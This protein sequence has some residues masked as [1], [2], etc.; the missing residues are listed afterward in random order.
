MSNEPKTSFTLYYSKLSR[1]VSASLR[2]HLRWSLCK[3]VTFINNT[4]NSIH[5]IRSSSISIR[6]NSSS[7]RR[8]IRNSGLSWRLPTKDDLLI[9]TIVVRREETAGIGI[10]IGIEKGTHTDITTITAITLVT[11]TIMAIQGGEGEE[12][13]E[14][15]TEREKEKERIV[16]RGTDIGT[17]TEVEGRG[18]VVVL[19]VIIIIIPGGGVL[20][21]LGL[22]IILTT[23]N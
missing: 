8:S 20:P 10:A 12:E 7:R 22:A 9:E 19:R 11:H 4:S 18:G 2:Y 17:G 15:E 16:A 5:S 14:E 21:A 6:N 3:A 1:S 13:E 23:T